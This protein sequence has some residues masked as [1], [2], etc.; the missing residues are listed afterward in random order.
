M[1]SKLIAELSKATQA[2]TALELAHA[3]GFPTRKSVNPTLYGMQKEGAVTMDN[4]AGAPRW[5]LSSNYQSTQPG[6]PSSP[7]KQSSSATQPGFPS[8]PNKQSRGGT[9]PGFPS[10]PNKQSRG[11]TQSGF[12]SS[13]NKQSSGGTQPGFPSSS[14]YQSRGGTQLSAQI[15]TPSLQQDVHHHDQLVV[16]P[17]GSL[18][19]QTMNLIQ[20]PGGFPSQPQTTAILNHLKSSNSS[21]TTLDLS[22]VAN[23]TRAGV[24]PILDQLQSQ[25]L[26]DQLSHRPPLW[27]ITQTGQLVET[28]PEQPG[29]DDTSSVSNEVGGDMQCETD[30]IH[31]SNADSDEDMDTEDPVH[32][33]LNLDLSHIPKENIRDRLIAIFQEDPEGS[34]T[35]L[36]LAKEIGDTYSRLQVQPFLETLASEGSIMKLP[37][38]PA[39]W[40]AVSASDQTVKSVQ[41]NRLQVCWNSF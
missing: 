20:H 5:T 17:E 9:Q 22:K 7:I 11:G 12:P 37:G 38:F 40:K 1:Q 31:H 29:L 4:S 19:T 26:I 30:S 23:M 14:N 10:S 24:T 32:S 33:G 15:S 2:K 13:L 3:L 6:F 27:R 36:E 16:S 28:S 8:S 34:R 41:Q 35:G 21:C 39:K 18:A 25:G